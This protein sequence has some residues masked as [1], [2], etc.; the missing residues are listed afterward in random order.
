[1]QVSRLLERIQCG[2]ISRSRKRGNCDALQLE[3]ARRS[4]SHASLH[5]GAHIKFEVGQPIRSVTLNIYSVSE[6][7][8]DQNL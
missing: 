3:A 1:M 2:L 7:S 8:C 6:L 5:W 4:A